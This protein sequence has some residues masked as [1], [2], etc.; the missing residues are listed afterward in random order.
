MLP[1]TVAIIASTIQLVVVPAVL[2][3]S[4]AI[5]AGALLTH[6]AAIN[7]RL[8]GMARERLNL[9]LGPAV[10]GAG[11]ERL[12]AVD[13]QI[14]NLL[15]QHRL[16]RNAVLAIFC[17][18]AAFVFSMLVIAMAVMAGSTDVANAALVLFLIGVATL[19]G[20]VVLTALEISAS[21][22]SLHYEVGEVMALQRPADAP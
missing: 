10:D 7:N 1:M 4:C 15:R 14:P 5:L 12:R 18:Q 13:A 6:Y 20:S 9:V 21:H 19:L 17:A 22:W 8:R 2:L 11:A 16:M 3:T